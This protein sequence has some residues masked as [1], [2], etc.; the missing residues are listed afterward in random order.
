MENLKME[1]P[2]QTYVRWGKRTCPEPNTDLVYAGFS[3]GTH[4]KHTGSGMNYLCL[5]EHPQFGSQGHDA[6]SVAII[7]GAEYETGSSNFMNYLNEHDV[8]C[9]VC[10]VSSPILMIPARTECFSGWK[11]EYAGYLMTTHYTH[12]GS[13]EFVCLDNDPEKATDRLAQARKV[14]CNELIKLVIL[15]IQAR[16]AAHD[17]L[18]QARD[19]KCNMLVKLVK[20]LIQACKAARDELVRSCF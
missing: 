16:K 18:V 9:A 10:R 5:P 1:F 15:L 3:A 13:K 2:S 8:P 12:V 11:T 17:E 20:L 7:Y 14:N 4:Y 19:V 6:S